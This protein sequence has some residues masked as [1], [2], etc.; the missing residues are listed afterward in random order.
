MDTGKWDVQVTN[1]GVLIDTSVGQWAAKQLTVANTGTKKIIAKIN[2]TTDEILAAVAAG[3]DAVPI[4]PGAAMTWRAA[5]IT[6]VAVAALTSDDS[7]IDWAATTTDA[8]G[9][10]VLG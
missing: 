7:V 6:N 3:E 4:A 9:G 10:F 8:A 5:A 2:S 1:S